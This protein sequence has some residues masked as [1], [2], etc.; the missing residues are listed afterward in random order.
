MVAFGGVTSVERFWQM[1]ARKA[2]RRRRLHISTVPAS[3]KYLT[4][5]NQQPC[6]LQVE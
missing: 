4:P 1:L 5:L 6:L 3:F 2:R